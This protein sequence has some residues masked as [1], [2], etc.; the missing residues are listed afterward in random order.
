MSQNT[1]LRIISA[2]ALIIIVALCFMAG[3]TQSLVLIF[4]MGVIISDE[5][6]CNFFKGTRLSKSYFCSLSLFVIPFFLFNFY[7]QEKMFHNFFINSSLV[8][9]VFLLFYLVFS[10]I[11][12]DFLN[13]KKEVIAYFSGAFV[14][15]PMMSLT[16]IFQTPSWNLFLIM[17][18]VVNYS[19]DT[20]AWFVG[21]NFGKNKLW[22]SV[23]PKKTLEGLLG[24]AVFSGIFGFTFW[25]YFFGRLEVKLFFLFAVFGIISQLGDLVQSKLKR[26][27][28]IKDSSSLIPGHGGFYDR[29]DS[30]L[31]LAP[32]FVI[33]IYSL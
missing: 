17:L 15:F 31:F 10:D 18:L 30:L 20:G 19:M 11:K 23:S 25:Y 12:S 16:S 21:K 1:I 6:F 29:L 33:S 14:L 26:H 24:G 5:I 7:I 9:N 4:L 8:L 28:S 2:L 3:P 32:F 13:K 27:C 22:P